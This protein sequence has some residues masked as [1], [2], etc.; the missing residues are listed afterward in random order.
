MLTP[1][2]PLPSSEEV[3][4]PVTCLVWA[5]NELKTVIIN[6]QMSKSFFMLLN[7]KMI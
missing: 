6:T 3:T 7:F 1:G 2:M 4:L 5:I